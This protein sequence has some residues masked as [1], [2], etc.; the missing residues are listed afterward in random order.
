MSFNFINK[1]STIFF[2]II[3]LS[4]Q[5]NL[6]L[7]KKDDNLEQKDEIKNFDYVDKL[8]FSFKSVSENYVFDFYSNQIVSYDFLQNKINK[9][10]IKNYEG[11]IE[12]KLPINIVYKDSSIF[13][14]NSK[15]EI[16]E[17]DINGKLINKY[18]IDLSIEDKTPISFS[19]IKN[20]FI[21][22]FKSGEIIRTNSKGRIVWVH[23]H[24]NLLNTPIKF[25]DNN[26]IILF[27]EEIL[28]L[29]F[30]SGEVIFKKDYKASNIIQSTGG[31]IV[32]YFN[33]IFFILPNSEFHA[34]D[35]FLFEEHFT[36]LSNIDI[37]TSLNNLHDDL[38][39]YKNLFVYLDDYNT[40]NTYDLIK[41]E[42]LV[43]NYFINNV[44][45]SILFNNSLIVKNHNKLE[46]YNIKNGK[47][48][49]NVNIEKILKKD[50]KIL[51]ALII[52]NKL[53]LFSNYGKLIIINKKYE[54]ETTIDLKIK[55]INKIYNYQDKIFISTEKGIT[56]IY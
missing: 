48:F 49:F 11:K 25:F 28:I 16:Q 32:N 34:L 51:K 44:E 33:I 23:K 30:N 47:K 17:F 54:I 53:H 52:N 21:I 20:D 29:S 38:H 46:F 26:L 8:D 19:L 50:S 3:V 42:Y 24:N 35:S 14:I 22:A 56:Y 45:S 4:C 9:I 6:E 10:R 18:L 12:N 2:C 55:N 31:K 5:N 36:E 27:P 40:I 1:L 7:L 15:G 43:S 41:N 39:V 13:S 37:N